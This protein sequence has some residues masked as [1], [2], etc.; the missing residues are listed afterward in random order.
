MISSAGRGAVS[1]PGVS[2]QNSAKKEFRSLSLPMKFMLLGLARCLHKY[3]VCQRKAY[4]GNA[5]LVISASTLLKLSTVRIPTTR[6]AWLKVAFASPIKRLSVNVYLTGP[7]LMLWSSK[8]LRSLS[9]QTSNSS[10]DSPP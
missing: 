10:G 5:C 2:G 6:A 1:F 4:A 8:A 7:M 9:F 3:L